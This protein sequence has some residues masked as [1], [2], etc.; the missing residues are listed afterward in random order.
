[1]RTGPTVATDVYTVGRTLAK[2]TIDMS[3]VRYTVDLP[4]P[5]DVPLFERYDS[6][7]RL[8]KRAT[9][10]RPAQRFSSADELAA[11]CK[12]VL[13]EILAEQTGEPKPGTSVLFSPPHSTFRA[14]LALQRTDVFVNGQRHEVHPNAHSV[15]R[16]LPEPLPADDPES[17]WRLDWEDALVALD[18]GKLKAA[19]ACFER[20]VAALPG[21]AAPK[22]AA[23]AIGELML[24][25][26]EVADADRLRRSIERYYSTLWRTDRSTVS[27]AFGLARQLA[28]RSDRSGA[29]EVLD[30][31]PLASRHYGEGQLTSVLML[32]DA[33]PI[34]QITEAD[35]RD[36]ARR[37]DALA[38]TEPAPCRCV[39]SCSEPPWTGY[40]PARPRP[41][42]PCSGDHSTNAA[43]G[44]RSRRRFESSHGMRRGAATATPSSTW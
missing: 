12:G 33:R 35:L 17:D 14:D 13:R 9:D 7:H 18:A 1:V 38:E 27:A 20:V 2:L 31:V 42:I 37:V 10:P 4:D 23:A 3:D 36:A 29:I 32:L 15:A 40:G 28:G 43:C 21:E 19:H 44:R 8:L 24:D 5:E 41:P 39:R 26:N 34:E 22:L 25:A 16:A 11:Q 6:Y 30:Q